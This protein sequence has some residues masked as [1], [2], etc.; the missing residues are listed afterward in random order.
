MHG[1]GRRLALR[2]EGEGGWK[3][4]SGSSILVFKKK[5]ELP[6]PWYLFTAMDF[7]TKTKLNISNSTSKWENIQSQLKQA[8]N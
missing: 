6:W 2:R 3:R 4:K 1:V 8:E 7:L 5:K